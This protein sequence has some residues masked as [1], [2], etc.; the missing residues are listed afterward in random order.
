MLLS[1]KTTKE[2]MSYH[3]SDVIYV[4]SGALSSSVCSKKIKKDYTTF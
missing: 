1:N 3:N 2:S 4:Y